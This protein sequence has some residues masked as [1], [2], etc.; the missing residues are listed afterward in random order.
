MLALAGAQA[1]GAQGR[2]IASLLVPEAA[3]AIASAGKATKRSEG[4]PAYLPLHP[5]SEALREAIATQK[6]SILVEAVFVLKRKARADAAGRE[7]ELASIYGHVRALG[8]LAGIQ[9][10]SITYGKT[11]TFYEESYLIDGPETKRRLPDPPEPAPGA[12]PPAETAYAL[13][14]DTSFGSNLYR[15]DYSYSGD[16]ILLSSSNLTRMS[17]GPIPVM[18]PGD[19]DTRLLVIQAE[20]GILFYVAS[21]ARAPG[22]MKG[23]LEGSFA[24]RAE[25]LFKW[26]SDRMQT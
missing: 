13:Q 9:Y 21:G 2:T 26:F 24:N 19:L 15:Y 22:L 4:V 6:S 16:A 18:A 14:R 25:A 5:A 11:R 3:S 8:S 23:H 17:L 1:L 7:A 10:Y 20:D 12:I